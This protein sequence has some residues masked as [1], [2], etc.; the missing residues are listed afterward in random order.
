MDLRVDP[1]EQDRWVKAALQ[2]PVLNP[3]P[4]KSWYST[5]LADFGYFPAARTPVGRLFDKVRNK[6]VVI[7]G[8]DG[9]GKTKLLRDHIC[10][11]REGRDIER[12]R[13]LSGCEVESVAYPH[14]VCEFEVTRS[15]GKACPD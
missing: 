12:R 13:P 3:R 9:V 6:K 1:A 8:L 2:G 15:I 11:E 5:I 10:L 14:N 7:V 4:P